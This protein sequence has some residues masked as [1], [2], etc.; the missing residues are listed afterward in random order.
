M[1]NNVMKLKLELTLIFLVNIHSGE[2]FIYH[3]KDDNSAKLFYNEVVKFAGDKN[4]E[5]EL[6]EDEDDDH[7]FKFFFIKNKLKVIV[8][9]PSDIAPKDVVKNYVVGNVTVAPGVDPKGIDCDCTIEGDLKVK[10]ISVDLDV[11]TNNKYYTKTDKFSELYNKICNYNNTTYYSINEELLKNHIRKLERQCLKFDDGSK[12]IFNFSST[13]DKLSIMMRADYQLEEDDLMD[14]LYKHAYQI[15]FRIRPNK[16][17]LY[18]INKDDLNLSILFK[19][20][21]YDNILEEIG[22]KAKV[23]LKNKYK[24]DID[25]FNI[26]IY[27]KTGEGKY[28]RITKNC[29][30]KTG[31]YYYSINNILRS[32]GYYNAVENLKEIIKKISEGIDNYS[33][34]EGTPIEQLEGKEKN[35]TE[36][37]FNIRQAVETVKRSRMEEDTIDKSEKEVEKFKEQLGKI[38]ENILDEISKKKAEAKAEKYFTVHAKKLGAKINELVDNIKNATFKNTKKLIVGN[39]FVQTGEDGGYYISE[40]RFKSYIYD[41]AMDILLGDVDSKEYNCY[42]VKIN[43]YYEDTNN[44]KDFAD[45]ISKAVQSKITE[46]KFEILFDQEGENL[47]SDKATTKINKIFNK[48]KNLFYEV[49]CNEIW[50]EINHAIYMDSVQAQL[51]EG[52]KKVSTSK[53]AITSNTRLRVCYINENKIPDNKSDKEFE[54]AVQMLKKLEE[55]NKKAKE[56]KERIYKQE[57]DKRKAMKKKIDD[58]QKKAKED[59]KRRKENIVK[60]INDVK[61]IEKKEPNEQESQSKNKLNNVTK[62]PQAKQNCCDRCCKS[63]KCC[64]KRT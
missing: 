18:D 54:E 8:G 48:Y 26:D 20:D 47:L 5:I 62:T 45:G 52:D 63:C 4:G 41:V 31:K 29:Q 44:I 43:D 60:C 56:E 15:E 61:N 10:K 32:E 14:Y 36:D 7:K 3:F 24:I 13:V 42:S 6:R 21:T 35:I 30:L 49:T 40:E 27:Y 23:I 17:L 28:Q 39:W 1:R 55:E 2:S 25:K 22:N 38:K 58:A 53:K 64:K 19:Q 46:L 16:K 51:Y 57:E 9:Y 12:T 59:A 37:M 34:A 50:L 33:I 11:D